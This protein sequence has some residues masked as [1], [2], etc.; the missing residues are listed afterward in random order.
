MN[1][2][3]RNISAQQGIVLIT[4]IVMLVMMSLIAITMIRLGTRHTQVVNNEQLRVEA[5]AAAN[6]ALD[7][8]LNDSAN[9]WKVYEGAGRIEKVNIGLNDMVAA[10]TTA[11]DVT[12]RQLQCKRIRVLKNEELI[13]SQGG[14]NFVSAINASCF[15][16]GQTQM[17]IVDTGSGASSSGDSLCAS[18]L[19]EVQAQTSDA[20]LLGANAVITQ[21][22]NVRRSVLELD[23]CD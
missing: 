2:S 3:N 13:S 16:G 4:S 22:V 1:T 5:E 19:Y 21:G 23:S 12:V 11:I 18:A 9:T 8:V 15:G 14:T 6:Y 17:T 7:L 10:S 20:R